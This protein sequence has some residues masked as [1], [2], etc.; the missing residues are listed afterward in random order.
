MDELKNRIKDQLKEFGGMK[1]AHEYAIDWLNTMEENTVNESVAV[2]KGRYSKFEVGKM[3]IFRYKAK[4]YLDPLPYY[5]MHPVII[6][7][8]RNKKTK[9]YIE[10][11]IN[12]NYLPDKVRMLFL[13]ALYNLYKV[14]I[15]DRTLGNKYQEARKQKPLT[16]STGRYARALMMIIK[17]Y[18]LE[19]A[20]KNYI[21]QRKKKIL[22]I[23]YEN[24][25]MGYFLLDNKNFK[26]ATTPMVHRH[27]AT[28][29]RKKLQER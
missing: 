27:Y 15:H 9:P 8:G 12:I 23:S 11:G 16:M 17:K 20:I 7:L 28:Y 18:H 4:T 13:N 25:H 5:D 26:G 24:W 10:M 6:S 1:K 19:F 21:P 2:L 29:V 22:G 3:Y 14:Q